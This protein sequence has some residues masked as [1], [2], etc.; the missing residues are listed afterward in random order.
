MKRLPAR[1]NEQAQT[2]TNLDLKD[3]IVGDPGGSNPK[4]LTP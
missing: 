3:L 1:P 2:G 4:S